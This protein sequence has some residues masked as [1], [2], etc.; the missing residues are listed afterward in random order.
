MDQDKKNITPS[1]VLMNCLEEFG[2]CE[3]TNLMVIWVNEA[4]DL[5]WQSTAMPL[6]QGVG[7][8]EVTKKCILAKL[9][10]SD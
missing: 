4:G 6:S 2:A 1:Q 8:L 5:C 9:L 3:P 7:M 10:S